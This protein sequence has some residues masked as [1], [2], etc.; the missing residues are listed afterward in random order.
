MKRRGFNRGVATSTSFFPVTYLWAG[1]REIDRRRVSRVLFD[2]GRSV[3]LSGCL[4]RFIRNSP[5][6]A[7]APERRKR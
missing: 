4:P 5:E 2:S 6:L 7:L 3:A 1:A